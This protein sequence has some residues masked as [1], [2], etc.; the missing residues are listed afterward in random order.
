MSNNMTKNK[1]IKTMIFFGFLM[2]AGLLIVIASLMGMMKE[3]Y[4]TVNFSGGGGIAGSST[5]SK[6]EQFVG[7]A[8]VGII[9]F[10]V[11]AIVCWVAWLNTP[12]KE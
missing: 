3:M 1:Q 9:M 12:V 7:P 10:F 5:S 11:S 6:G 2:I 4:E 8:V